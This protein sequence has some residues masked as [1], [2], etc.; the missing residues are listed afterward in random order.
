MRMNVASPS[1]LSTPHCS[2]LGQHFLEIAEEARA[3]GNEELAIHLIKLAL[4]EFNEEFELGLGSDPELS[5]ISGIYG[6]SV[7][8]AGSGQARR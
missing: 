4:K 7:A 3:D 6:G 8:N 5:D 1:V 2:H